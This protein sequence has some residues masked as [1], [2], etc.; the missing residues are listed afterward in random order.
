M[1]KLIALA[2]VRRLYAGLQSLLSLRR[3]EARR[4]SETQE[5]KRLA[6]EVLPVLGGRSTAIERNEPEA[7]SN[8][9]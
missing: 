4:I 2:S 3:M 7:P 1:R 9:V 5:C 6:I 8:K